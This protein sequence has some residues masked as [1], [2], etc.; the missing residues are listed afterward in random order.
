MTFLLRRKSVQADH[1]VHKQHMLDGTIEAQG[2]CWLLIWSVYVAQAGPAM[3]PLESAPFKGQE[4]SVTLS[5]WDKPCVKT[6]K[7]LCDMSLSQISAIWSV[8]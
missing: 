4:P 2:V 8:S 7:E 5:V 3:H 6:F 1:F